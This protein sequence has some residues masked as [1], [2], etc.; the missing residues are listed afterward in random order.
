GVADPQAQGGGGAV[1]A[2]RARVTDAL[3]LE[4][5]PALGFD[6]A[7][8]LDAHGKLAGIAALKAPVVAGPAPAAGASATLT[9]VE[10]ILNFLDSSN[11]A[12]AAGG[13]AGV[14]AAKGSVVRVICVR[15]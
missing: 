5:A 2:A 3:S 10:T 4:P 8:V 7:A 13:A 11:V 1:S 15:K 14:E 6:G 12:P 9:P